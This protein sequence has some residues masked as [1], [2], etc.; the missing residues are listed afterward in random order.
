MPEEIKKAI[1]QLTKLL[2]SLRVTLIR[3][4]GVE[5]DDVIGTLAVRAVEEGF[6]VGIV[7][8]DKVHALLL[9][10]MSPE[11]FSNS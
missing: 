3:Q 11:S 1:P 7:S 8:P 6:H 5:A 9:L 10:C 2:S 4:A